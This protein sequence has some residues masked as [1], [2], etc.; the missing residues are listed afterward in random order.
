MSDTKPTKQTYR[1]RNWPEYNAALTRHG[2][3]TLWLDEA[4]IGQWYNARKSG[5]RGASNTYSDLAIQCALT[6]KGVYG[7]ALRA[8]QGFPSSLLKLMH[9]LL[10]SPHYSTCCRR[11]QRL[12]VRI[13]RTARA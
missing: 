6:L 11:Q 7:L 1:I 13:T 4:V 12:E 8:A 2:S 5:R 10:S 9:V 3:F